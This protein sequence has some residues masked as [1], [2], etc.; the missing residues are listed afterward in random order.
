MSDFTR[1]EP[2]ITHFIIEKRTCYGHISRMQA[3]IARPELLDRIMSGL[4]SSPVTALL[5]PRQCGKTTIARDIA[6]Q[7]SGAYFDLENPR[8]Q[9]RLQNAQ[10]ILESINGLIVLDEIQHQPELMPLLRVLSDRQ[11]LPARF[12]ILGSASP[13]LMKGCSETLAGR[14]HFVDMSGFSMEE[15]GTGQTDALWLRGGFPDSFLAANDAAS[16]KWRDDFIQTFLERDLPLLGIGA[17]SQTLR[18]FWTMTA[19][20]HG[21]TWNGTEIGA[22]LGV[23]HQTSRRYVDSLTDAFVLRQLQPWFENTGKRVV[24]SQKV[25]VRDSGLLHA[26]LGI[27]DL[28]FLQSHPKLGAS[29]E[30]FVIEQILNWAGERNAYF[31]ATHSRAELDLMV[32]SKGK[33]WGFEIKYQDAPKITKSMRIAMEDLQ[34]ER[35]WVVFPGQVGYPMDDK[36]ECIPL[37]Q[38]KNVRQTILDFQ[39]T[40]GVST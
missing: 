32:L 24:K 33:R 6:S 15:T 1:L 20:Y 5:G 16:L 21:Q 14:V 19:H 38:L 23:S 36:I 9:A 29:W 30:G 27:L 31:W 7:H 37:A 34:L 2:L 11:P 13:T 3:F 10:T 22:S 40:N 18:R 35:L 12:L 26:L 17:P 25:Y 4:A 8:D 28:P 39:S